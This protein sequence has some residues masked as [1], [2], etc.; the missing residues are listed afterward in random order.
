MDSYT[1][2]Y[3]I[4]G[5]DF[6]T[7]PDSQVVINGQ[8]VANPI[9]PFSM[10]G[11]FTGW[12]TNAD[13]SGVMWD[14]DTMVVTDNMVL[15]PIYQEN[16][17][18]HTFMID[19]ESYEVDSFYKQP[20]EPVIPDDK[21]GYTFVG[22]SP[23]ANEDVID[24][25]VYLAPAEDVVLYPVWSANSYSV[26]YDA[27]GGS[28]VYKPSI[29]E[30][31]EVLVAPSAPVKKGYTFLGWSYDIAGDERVDFNYDTMPASN[32]T[33]YAQWGTKPVSVEFVVN[34]DKVGTYYYE[35]GDYM[36]PPNIDVPGYEV[37]GW[38]TNLSMGT[39]WDFEKTPV[40]DQSLIFNAIL[41]PVTYSVTFSYSQSNQVVETYEYGEFVSSPDVVA[42]YGYEF[43][44]WSFD[45]QT[46]LDLNDYVL[47]DDVVFYPV[48][49]PIHK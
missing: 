24:F 30:Y 13:G 21:E 46:V 31:D 12:N 15:Y 28:T 4:N 16:Y 6:L 44:G 1:V 22:W 35:K 32:I 29:V 26:S 11:T 38:T 9:S 10:T 37:V 8:Y 25:D 48:Y 33:L 2:S 34:G 47:D 40:G 17:Y 23:L 42:P 39:M 14:F 20:V 41:E 27:L 7:V 5:G 3:D 49:A 45:G 18:T 36:D 43:L 19:D